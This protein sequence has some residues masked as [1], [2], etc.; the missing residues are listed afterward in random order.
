MEF[1]FYGVKVGECK[2]ADLLVENEFPKETENIKLT[3]AEIFNDKTVEDTSDRIQIYDV[4]LAGEYSQEILPPFPSFLPL[5]A[6]EFSRL[7]QRIYQ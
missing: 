3:A 1:T 7:R 6:K 5:Y 4:L 2:I